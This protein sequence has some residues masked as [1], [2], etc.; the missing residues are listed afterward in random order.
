[1]HNLQPTKCIVCWVSTMVRF[2]YGVVSVVTEHESVK[3]PPS[4]VWFYRIQSSCQFLLGL[5]EYLEVYNLFLSAWSNI[6]FVYCCLP[7]VPHVMRPCLASVDLCCLY[8]ASTWLVWMPKQIQGAL[9]PSSERMHGCS[10]A[11]DANDYHLVKALK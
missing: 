5:N 9:V 11:P 3:C 6:S 8:E 2:G 1:M 4:I 7:W 10:N